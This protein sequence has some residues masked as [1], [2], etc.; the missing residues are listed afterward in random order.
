M[1]PLP[2]PDPRFNATRVK[3]FCYDRDKCTGPPGQADIAR[4]RDSLKACM[5]VARKG[6]GGRGA[7]AEAVDMHSQ[8]AALRAGLLV[9][10]RLAPS[11][12]PQLA[13]QRPGPPSSAP[14]VCSWL[15]SWRCPAA[16]TCL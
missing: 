5:Q 13:V 10:T 14:L 1:R 6:G 15:C 12:A 7:R 11:R 2:S 3:Y 9:N 4:F 16:T 8:L